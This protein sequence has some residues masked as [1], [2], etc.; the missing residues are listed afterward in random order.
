M[1]VLTLWPHTRPSVT[2]SVIRPTCLS[3]TNL[4]P[5]NGYSIHIGVVCNGLVSHSSVSHTHYLL[6]FILTEP[7]HRRSCENFQN[8]ELFTFVDITIKYHRW[9]KYLIWTPQTRSW[10]GKLTF[11]NF[12]ISEQ[13]VIV[14]FVRI[15]AF[16]ANIDVNDN[17]QLFWF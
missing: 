4:Y 12:S 17:K 13:D 11:R 7:W 6:T 16:H 5:W 15:N 14:C 3:K 1:T 8:G 2:G 9:F 10:D